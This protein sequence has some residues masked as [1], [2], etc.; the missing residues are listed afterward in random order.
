MRRLSMKKV[1]EILR[2]KFQTDISVR[3]IS[4]ALNVPRSTVSDYCKRFEQTEYSINEFLALDESKTDALL[5][6]TKQP[7]RQVLKRPLPNVEYIHQEIAKKGVTFELLWHE[8]KQQHPDGYGLSQFK[9]YYYKF[10]QKLSPTMRQTYIPGYELFIDYSG[11]CVSYHDI[12]T[13]EVYKAQIFVC[14]LGHSG[15]AFVHATP[16]QKKEYFIK[17]HVLAYQFYGGAAKVNV[18]DNLKSAIISNNKKGVVVNESYA[19][20]CRHYGCTVDPARPKKPQ[21]KGIVEQAVQG[22]Q[23]WILA[24]FRHRTFFSVDEINQAIAPL[25]DKYNHKV[26]NHI[27]KSRNELFEKEEKEHLLTLPLNTFVYK[28]IKKATVDISYHVQL[29]KSLYSV[30]FQYLKEKVVIKYSVHLV[31]VYYKDKLIATHPRLFRANEKS[32]LKEHMPKAHQ[33]YKEQM[34]PKRLLN[35][36]N[37]IGANT[38]AFVDKRFNSAQYPV[39]VYKSLI[40]ILSKAKIHGNSELDDALGYALSIN[41]YSVKSIDS[42]L[43][44]KLHRQPVNTTSQSTVHNTHDNLRGPNYYK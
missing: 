19:E 21:D 23:R 10:K 12:F 36:A 15:Y 2:L 17:S 43:V 28:E 33:I 34:N 35:W 37:N 18:V 9:A 4:R 13:G 30:P 38:H 20:L 40:A 25:L 27:G 16:S 3:Q 26:M 1:K 24:V 41:A 42:I 7:S 8:Y 32:T 14:V 5:F 6:G 31:E 44:K 29:F 11:L 39:H 22:I